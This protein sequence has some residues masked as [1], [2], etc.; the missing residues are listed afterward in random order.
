MAVRALLLPGADFLPQK[1][2]PAF[3]M[4]ETAR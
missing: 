1:R 2:A 3:E 4:S